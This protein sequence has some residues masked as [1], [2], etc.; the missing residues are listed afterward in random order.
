M[1]SVLVCASLLLFQITTNHSAGV[2]CLDADWI[3][4][5]FTGGP[6]AAHRRRSLYNVPFCHNATD[7]TSL[8]GAFNA[9]LRNVHPSSR[10]WWTF[11]LPWNASKVVSENLA[12]HKHVAYLTTPVQV[13]HVQLS[14]R[15]RWIGHKPQTKDVDVFYWCQWFPKGVCI[16]PGSCNIP[17]PA[18]PVLPRHIIHWACLKM[19]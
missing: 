16:N 15:W 1:K 18:H 12:A 13:L 14:H 5:Y 3:S 6:W 2:A 10:L 9:G 8:E 19:P 17:F 11:L 4:W 7:E